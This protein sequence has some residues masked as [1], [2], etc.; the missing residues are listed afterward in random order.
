FTILAPHQARRVRKIG[1]RNWKDVTGGHIDPTMVYLLRLPS[2]KK[3]NLFF[4]DGPI[5][6]AVAF[7]GL[8][9]NGEQFARRLAGAF[10]EETRPWPELVHIATDGETYG[11]HHPHGEMGLSYAL[12]YIRSHDLAAITNY[13]EYLERHPPT[14]VAEIIENTSWSCVHGIERWRANCGCNSGGHA[15][16][17]QEWRA[18]LR[19]ALDWLRDDI[20][21]RFEEKARALLKDPWAA[22]NDY[23][24]VVLDRSPES[25]NA[26]LAKHAARELQPEERVTAL[27][28]LELERHAMLMYTSCGWF[29]DEPSGI[30]TVQ[31]IQYAGRVVQLASE[32]FND[33]TE[34]R[35]L[36][37]LAKAKSNI[38]EHRDGALIY[39][40]FVKPAFVDLRK[41]ALHYAIRSLFEPY[42]PQA[43]VYCYNVERQEGLSLTGDGGEQKRLCIGRARFTSTVTLESEVLTFAAVDDG[44]FNPLGRVRLC[45]GEE[46]CA[47]LIEELRSAF[48]SGRWDE[49]VRLFD[50]SFEGEAYNLT[51][52]FKDEQRIILNRI[53]ESEWRE[54]E[55]AFDSLYPHLVA[56]LRALARIGAPAILPRAFTAAAEFALNTRLRREIESDQMDFESVASL[57]ADAEGAKI[58]LDVATLEYTLRMKLE[59]LAEEFQNRPADL[60]LLERLSR[61]VEFAISLPFE[62]KVWKI[63]NVCYAL[64]QTVFIEFQRRAGQ[65]DAEASVWAEQ[66]RSLAE[67][68]TLR[69]DQPAVQEASAQAAQA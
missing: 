43:R 6:R 17:N 12:D 49:V 63:Q 69:V 13:G 57:I 66:F 36:E 10:S 39:Q 54:A 62:V 33:E 1:G 23:I 52:L 50:S 3:M 32:L 38:P 22:R 29:F 61:M 64:L 51:A 41:V 67:K 47:A 68:L 7:E 58:E 19:E 4:Y 16:W 35:F 30:E 40:K 55:A 20:A 44:H 27:K 65:G 15:G 24:D 25:L 9:D 14:H 34:K 2:G 56:L 45:R 18:P 31:V 48:S 42:D 8:L 53:A 37:L 59:G 11:H 60:H 21:P 46:A 5:A 28:L 26:F